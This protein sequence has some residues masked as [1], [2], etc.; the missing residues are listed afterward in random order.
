MS[1][2]GQV[3]DLHALLAVTIRPP[4]QPDLTIEFVVDTGFTGALALPL[5]AIRAMGLPFLEEMRANL[6]NDTD[7]ILPVHLVTIVWHNMEIRVRVLAT[8]R[9]PLIGTAL[10]S[11]NY[12]GIDFRDSGDVLIEL[13]P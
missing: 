13:R 11:G 2:N 7:V 3:S 12:L 5:A 8:G 1:M 9:R 10:L 6:A 4:G